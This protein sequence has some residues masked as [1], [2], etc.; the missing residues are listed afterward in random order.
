MVVE[1]SGVDADGNF[2]GVLLFVDEAGYMTELEVYAFG[3]TS[4]GR[5]TG[6]RW[7]MPTVES[8]RLAEWYPYPGGDQ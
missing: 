4:D 2:V 1:G 3:G 8:F 5:V 7:G 6:D